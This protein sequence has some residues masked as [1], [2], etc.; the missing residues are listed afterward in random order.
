MESIAELDLSLLLLVPILLCI[1]FALILILLP[2]LSTGL[3]PFEYW[4]EQI[5]YFVEW[6]KKRI[7]KK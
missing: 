5:K 4:C 3:N 7:I 6:I 1:A 2:I